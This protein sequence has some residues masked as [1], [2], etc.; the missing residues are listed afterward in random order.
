MNKLKKF[1]ILPL[2]FGLM[3]ILGAN[4]LH[5]QKYKVAAGWRAGGGPNGITLKLVPVKGF[6]IEGI[7]GVYPFGESV[8]VMLQRSR[9]IFCIQALQLYTGV[10]AHRR[11]NYRSGLYSDPIN[12]TFEAIAPPGSSGWG[13]D[14]V[15]GIELKIPLLPIAVSAEVKPMVEWTN[16]GAIMYGLDPAL[17][18]KL[19][20]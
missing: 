13:V 6:A 15:A 4:E 1:S 11:F 19:A 12:G 17:G 10:G 20:F 5:A 2:L 3:I 8:T 9:P 16:A 14:A 7:Y 18:L